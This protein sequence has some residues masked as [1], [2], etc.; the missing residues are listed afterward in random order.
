MKPY[1]RKRKRKGKVVQLL[2]YGVAATFVPVMKAIP[3][4][5]I[6]LL[7]RIFGEILYLIVPR[8][9]TIA[10][11]N[12]RKALGSEKT[13][14]EISALARRSWQ[15][16]CLTCFEMIKFHGVFTAQDARERLAKASSEGLEIL[17]QKARKIHEES[18]GCILVTP[19]LGNWEFLPHVS[20]VVG[21]PLVVV[22]RPLDNVYL[23]RFIYQHRAD[24]GQIIIP[25]KNI[26][27]TLYNT[28]RQGK[29]IGLLPDQGI[30][31]GIPVDFFGRKA[32]TTPVPALLSVTFKRPIVVVACC[33]KAQGRGYEGFVSDPLWPGTYGSEKGEIFRLTE[34]MNKTMEGII[35]KYPE[36]YFWIHNRWKT[37]RTKREL[38]G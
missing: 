6:H 17:F 36:Q 28:L 25:K 12:L 35:R 34:E 29:S 18:G 38:F 13:E 4:P 10:I 20:A 3:H 24:T 31:Q 1:R 7:S 33:H 19:H 37:Y 21:I 26:L 9:R 11:E 5:V 23:E 27:M 14:K 32:L 15:S 22:A 2:E 30:R 16:F 8:R